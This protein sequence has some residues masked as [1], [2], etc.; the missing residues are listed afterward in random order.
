MRMSFRD[1]LGSIYS[2]KGL[3]FGGFQTIEFIAVTEELE[4]LRPGVREEVVAEA[5]Y[6]ACWID[7]FP[8]I[9]FYVA[10]LESRSLL[11]ALLISACAYVCEF[12]RFYLLG[13]SLFLSH[14]CRLWDW[15]KFPASVI[16]AVLLW[17]ESRAASIIVL[18]FVAIQGWLSI[19]TCVIFF[20]IR[21]VGGSIVKT[22]LG[23]VHPTI[24]N[25]EGMALNHVIDRWR[26]KL[27]AR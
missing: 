9:A 4:V 22:L 11:L 16:V 12:I 24:Y 17:P 26:H 10:F 14:V 2:R 27:A 21:M 25:Y 3:R 1:V 20:P 15:V 13:P 8:E 23:H 7:R 6:L 5:H 18:V 19:V